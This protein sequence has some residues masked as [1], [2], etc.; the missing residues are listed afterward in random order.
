MLEIPYC[1]PGC[2]PPAGESYCACH[3]RVMASVECLRGS[4]NFTQSFREIRANRLGISLTK[5]TQIERKQMTPNEY[6]RLAMRTQ[7][8][9]VEALANLVKSPDLTPLVHSVI[10][11]TGEAGELASAIQKWMYYG[12]PLDETNVI[13][14]FGDALWYIA[15]GLSA[16]GWNLEDVMKLNIQK[17]QKRYPEKFTEELAAE[18]NRNRAAERQVLE[19][20]ITPPVYKADPI[21]I[22]TCGLGGTPEQAGQLRLVPGVPEQVVIPLTFPVNWQ[23]PTTYQREQTGAGFAELPEEKETESVIDAWEIAR[24]TAVN[25]CSGQDLERALKYIEQQERLFK[26]K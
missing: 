26:N 15:E 13:E 7:C 17:L 1:W 25:Y 23:V 24:R 16:L 8:P 19:Q 3:C 4:S 2:N 22:S 18:E 6:Q 10:G 21:D 20:T 12:K 5:E 11:L 14:E 9:Q